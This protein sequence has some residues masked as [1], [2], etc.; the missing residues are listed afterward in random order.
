VTCKNVNLNWLGQQMAKQ[1]TKT[2]VLISVTETSINYITGRLKSL[3]ETQK[4]QG[5]NTIEEIPR[6]WDVQYKQEKDFLHKNHLATTWFTIQSKVQL[7]GIHRFICDYFIELFLF[8]LRALK[9]TG[10]QCFSLFTVS[11]PQEYVNQWMTLELYATSE[12][13]EEWK[14]MDMTIGT[15]VWQQYLWDVLYFFYKHLP[16]IIKFLTGRRPS[17]IKSCNYRNYSIVGIV[18]QF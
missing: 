6:F 4:K 11:L 3:K 2:F 18:E 7:L 1:D 8:F 9:N 12:F 15:E 13:N 14:I 16:V 5:L 17:A 10:H